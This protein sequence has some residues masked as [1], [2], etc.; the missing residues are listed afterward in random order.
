MTRQG[1]ALLVALLLLTLVLIGGLVL[2]MLAKRH[3]G[4]GGERRKKPEEIVDPWVEA[5]KRVPTPGL[6][7]DPDDPLTPDEPDEV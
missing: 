4:D 5:G 7:V 1:T 3:W 6:G 2:L